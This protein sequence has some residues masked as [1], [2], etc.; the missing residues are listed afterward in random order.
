MLLLHDI[1]SARDNLL[2]FGVSDV[3]IERSPPVTAAAL[4]AVEQRLGHRLPD[5][6]QQ[7]YLAEAGALKFR[8]KTQLLGD[9]CKAGYT[10]LL[11]P[12]KVA[13]E[14]E[15]QIGMAEDARRE[16]LDKAD[17][18]YQLL[19]RDWPNWIPIFR[20][21]NG[22]RLGA[23]PLRRRTSADLSAAAMDRVGFL[24]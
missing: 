22:D 2:A 4:A 9:A 8:W 20:F 5:D 17:E 12:Q 3:S 16:G 13:K 15:E 14:F 11:S 19:V 18:G 24:R 7:V 1:E 21:P 23:D 10:E 6:L